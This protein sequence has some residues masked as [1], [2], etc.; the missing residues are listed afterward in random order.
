MSL[1]QLPDS[2]ALI[3]LGQLMKRFGGVLPG[4]VAAPVKR[5]PEPEPDWRKVKKTC[6]HCGKSKFIDPGFGFA[7]KRGVRRPQSWCVDCRAQGNYESK[8]RK[9]N[10]V[11]A[12]PE[13]P[14]VI[15]RSRR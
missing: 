9:Y 7:M 3:A 2:D 8:P 10:T 4:V 15:K 6:P 1:D 13:R 14:D 11:N 5:A 12:S